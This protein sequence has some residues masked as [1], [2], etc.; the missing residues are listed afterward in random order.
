MGCS[1]LEFCPLGGLAPQIRELAS[2]PHAVS[3]PSFTAWPT[4]EVRSRIIPINRKY[5]LKVL[6]EACDYYVAKKRRMTFQYIL[7]VGVNDTDEQAR[8]L[9]KIARHLSAKIKLIPYDTVEGGVAV[10]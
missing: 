1:R 3:P 8:E 10:A 2:Q 5:P 7:I 4:D 6:L 9:A